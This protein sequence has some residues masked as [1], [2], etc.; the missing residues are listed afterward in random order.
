MI[1][2]PNTIHYCGEL[3]MPCISDC[4]HPSLV[5]VGASVI[6]VVRSSCEDL[7]RVNRLLVRRSTSVR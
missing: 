1:I 4:S 7:D 3:V 2:T 5:L 6:S